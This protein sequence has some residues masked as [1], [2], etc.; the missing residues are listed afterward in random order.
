MYPRVA[1]LLFWQQQQQLLLLCLLLL[2]L[3]LLLFL[4]LLLLICL[5]AAAAACFCC[6]PSYTRHPRCFSYKQWY[7]YSVF[8]ERKNFSTPLGSTVVLVRPR[9]IPIRYFSWSL[10]AC[11]QKRRRASARRGEVPPVSGTFSLEHKT[12]KTLCTTSYEVAP[13]ACLKY[14][15]EPFPSRVSP[16][17]LFGAV[18]A[19]LP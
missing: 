19:L 14:A 7:C 15:L 11:T 17:T 16:Q 6:S 1:I 12:T 8:F 4:C 13:K 5:L 18:R 9:L 10:R 2:L 3:C